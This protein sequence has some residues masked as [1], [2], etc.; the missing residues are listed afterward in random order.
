LVDLVF[1][2]FKKFSKKAESFSNATKIDEQYYSDILKKIKREKKLIWNSPISGIKAGIKLD[3]DV[4]HVQWWIYSLFIVYFP[5]ILL[6]K[7]KR[8]KVVVSVHNIFPHEKNKKN[9]FFDNLLSKII[10][11]FTNAIIVHNK[12]N[13]QDFIKIYKIKKDKIS[14][15][16]HGSM[17]LTIKK[18]L[19]KKVARDKLDLGNEKKIILFFGYIRPY[20]GVDVL[21]EAFSKVF[22]KNKDVFLLIAGQLWNDEWNRYQKIINKNNLS[23]HIRVDLGFVPENQIQYYLSAA[24]LVVLPYKHLDTHGGVGALA[25]AFKKPIIATDVG[26]SSD[27]VLDKSAL[28]RANDVS[29]LSEKLNTI[30]S[31]EKLLLKL[32]KDSDIISKSITWKSVAKKTID[33]Y[34]KILRP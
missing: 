11:L 25:V 34:S 10:F 7:L 16:T 13:M 4:L 14:V 33:V 9:L 1:L 18:D 27:Y 23:N 28:V 5:I 15:I 6:A 3:C 2:D 22:K 12:R 32:S 21:L 31:D 24:D 20:K 30:I 26:G 8:I 19:P 29:D 17:D